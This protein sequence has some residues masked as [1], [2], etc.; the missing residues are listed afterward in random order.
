MLVCSMHSIGMK[1]DMTYISLCYV[2]VDVGVMEMWCV[3]L[4]VDGSVVI[5]LMRL[6]LC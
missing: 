1:C 6:A 5:K 3:M 2:H 4:H